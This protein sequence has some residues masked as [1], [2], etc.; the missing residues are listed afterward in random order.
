MSKSAADDTTRF[1]HWDWL[2][3]SV[4]RHSGLFRAKLSSTTTRSERG[5]HDAAS[6]NDLWLEFADQVWGQ[7]WGA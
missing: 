4:F 6:I 5:T 2:F 7:V 1:G 3:L